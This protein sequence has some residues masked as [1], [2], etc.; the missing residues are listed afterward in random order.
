MSAVPKRGIEAA[1]VVDDAS[2]VPADERRQ[3]VLVVGGDD[4]HGARPAEPCAGRLRVIA[5]VTDPE[6]IDRLLEYVRR[7]GLPRARP[8]RRDLA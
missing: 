1:L 5:D 7:E 4:E 8:L 2:A 3:H 6:V